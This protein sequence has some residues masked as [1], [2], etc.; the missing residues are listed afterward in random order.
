MVCKDSFFS[1]PSQLGERE[2]EIE[3]I[4]KITVREMSAS[5]RDDFEILKARLEKETGQGHFRAALAV[6]SAFS[7]GSPIFNDQEEDARRLGKLKPKYLEPIIDAAI[8]LNGMSG[9]A[10]KPSE[11]ANEDSSPTA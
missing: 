3:N 8:D 4:G 6:V 11:E 1:A 10:G 7:D 5:A 9:D 2:V